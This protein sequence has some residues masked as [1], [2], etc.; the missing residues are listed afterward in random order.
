LL[1][2]AVAAGC[3]APSGFRGFRT[4]DGIG[5][6]ADLH[7]PE[8]ARSGSP[9]PLVV[10]AHQ[11]YRDRTS[12]APLVPRL[13][14]AGWAVLAVDRRGCGGSRGEVS[15]VA[16]LRGDALGNFHLDLLEGIT[17]V[18]DRPGVDASRIAI[19]ASGMSVGSAVTTARLEPSVR[20]LVLLSGLIPAEEEELLLRRPEL[21]VLLVAA[22]ADPRGVGLMRQYARRLTGGAQEYLELEAGSDG[23]P[24][25]WEGTDALREETGLADYIVWFLERT[26]GEQGARTAP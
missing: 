16:E 14:D 24:G 7:V 17:A 8:G 22:E 26:I 20:S 12:W 21:P 4:S 19:V 13:L 3:A 25:G 6:A 11:L 23:A 5:I 9:A 18:A 15:T 1:F 10:L 2:A